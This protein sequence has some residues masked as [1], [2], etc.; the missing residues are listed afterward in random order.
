MVTFTKMSFIILH[1]KRR[2]GLTLSQ[3]FAVIPLI[4][5]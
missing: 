2:I 4:N 1:K 5:Q 3:L